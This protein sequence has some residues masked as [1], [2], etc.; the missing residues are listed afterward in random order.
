MCRM[1]LISLCRNREAPK[2]EKEGGMKEVGG[3]KERWG[4]GSNLS[5]QLF[6]GTG[7]ILLSLTRGEP[8]DWESARRLNNRQRD[9]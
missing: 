5:C 8:S 3:G 1:I 7:S 2:S 9:P 6:S 4:G